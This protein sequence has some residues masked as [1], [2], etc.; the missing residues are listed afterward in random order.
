M[1]RWAASSAGSVAT[2]A[3]TQLATSARRTAGLV[4]QG[5][6]AGTARGVKEAAATS[7]PGAGACQRMHGPRQQQATTN[8]NRQSQSTH[9]GA[10][11]DAG[12]AGQSPGGEPQRARLGSGCGCGG[13]GTEQAVG[14]D[15]CSSHCEPPCSCAVEKRAGAGGLHAAADSAASRG[16]FSPAWRRDAGAAWKAARPGR[17]PR[18]V[19]QGQLGAAAA[20]GCASGTE[21]QAAAPCAGSG[22]CGGGAE[23]SCCCTGAGAAAALRQ[24]SATNRSASQ[25]EGTRACCAAGGEQPPRGLGCRALFRLLQGAAVGLASGR[26]L[27]HCGPSAATRA[28]DTGA[29]ARHTGGGEEGCREN[30]QPAGQGGW[31]SGGDPCKAVER[32]GG[33]PSAGGLAGPGRKYLPPSRPPSAGSQAQIRAPGGLQG[34]C[35]RV[36][37]AGESGPREGV[38]R[39]AG[40]WGGVPRAGDLLHSVLLQ[41][42]RGTERPPHPQRAGRNRPLYHSY[43]GGRR[44]H[45]GT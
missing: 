32:G 28:M 42:R 9:L 5:A 15:A 31:C 7:R 4:L 23:A 3:C 37:G 26:I 20:T 1:C 40:V 22:C 18:C 6:G 41:R 13:C 8:T 21:R 34:G 25:L 43:L 35:K 10:K 36:G 33:W 11:G 29:C 19:P 44:A 16:R 2:T 39:K 17:M 27:R 12:P 14:S 45:R 38:R 24:A 30:F